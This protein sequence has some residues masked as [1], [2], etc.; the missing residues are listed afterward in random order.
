MCLNTS[1]QVLVRH[2]QSAS[3]DKQ[4]QGKRL[5]RPS[6]V[7]AA[8]AAHLQRTV[9]SNKVITGPTYCSS[10]HVFT[11]SSWQ[12]ES[13]FQSFDLDGGGSIPAIPLMQIACFADHF[14]NLE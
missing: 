7:K 14:S 12:G 5:T 2:R 9:T 8:P 4:G 10:R 11:S 6:P 1:S 3:D 13:G